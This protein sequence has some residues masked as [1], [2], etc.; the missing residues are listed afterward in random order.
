MRTIRYVAIFQIIDS[1]TYIFGCQT[2]VFCRNPLLEIRAQSKK[3]HFL[4]LQE[5]KL[6][7]NTFTFVEAKLSL[8][9]KLI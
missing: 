5:S 7:Q 6:D 9:S 4:V 8:R 1:S 2:N 3:K